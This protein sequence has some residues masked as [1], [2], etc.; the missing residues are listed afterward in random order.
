MNKDRFENILWYAIQTN[1]R[2]EQVVY[3]RLLGKEYET[4]LPKIEVWSRR[5]DRKKRINVPMFK[6]YLFVHCL[7]QNDNWLNILKTPG[8]VRV[9]GAA[10]GPAPIPE[11]E[12]NSIRI[13]LNNDTL[14]NPYPFL[15]VGKRVRIVNGPLT[16]AEGILLETHEEKNKL[17]V[18]VTILQRSVSIEIDVADVQVIN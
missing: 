1:S 16:G 9:I 13:L 8:V 3:D 2:H 10:E 4:F 15:N 5:K 14:V 11:D 12:I 17:I 6:G 18:S 7:L